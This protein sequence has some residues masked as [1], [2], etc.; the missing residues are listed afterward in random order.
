MY[1]GAVNLTT[2]N[3]IKGGGRIIK[4]LNHVNIS[5]EKNQFRLHAKQYIEH[6]EK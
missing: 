6:Y 3:Q 5:G 1:W 2:D 4:I